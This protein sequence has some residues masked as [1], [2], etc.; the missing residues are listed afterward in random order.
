MNLNNNRKNGFYSLLKFLL[1][2]NNLLLEFSNLELKINT[3]IDL[4][5]YNNI[6]LSFGQIIQ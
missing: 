3:Q 1:R 5:Y 2:I 6:T 4:K